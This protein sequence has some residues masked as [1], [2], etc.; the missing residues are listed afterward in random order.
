[1]E[2]EVVCVGFE[3]MWEA[4]MGVVCSD[5]MRSSTMRWY[6]LWN[7]WLEEWV[8]V[9]ARGVWIGVR[10]FLGGM[11]GGQHALLWWVARVDAG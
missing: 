2:V 11:D 8:G 9:R 7:G 10:E 5:G 6:G 4:W 3:W 1:M